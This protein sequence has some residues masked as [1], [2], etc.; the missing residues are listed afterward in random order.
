[1]ANDRSHYDYNHATSGTQH[2]V[3]VILIVMVIALLG[4]LTIGLNILD[5]L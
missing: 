4:G 3:T 5:H 1:M 2:A